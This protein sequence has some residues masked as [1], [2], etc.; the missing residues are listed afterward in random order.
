MSKPREGANPEPY[1][2]RGGPRKSKD[3]GSYYAADEM[4]FRAQVE[5]LDEDDKLDGLVVSWPLPYLFEQAPGLTNA[6][7]IGK[8]AQLGRLND[9]LKALGYD[10]NTDDDIPYSP[11]VLPWLDSWF[12][13]H[14]RPFQMTLNEKG[15]VDSTSLIKESNLPAWV[16]KHK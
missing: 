10:P 12:L 8:K 5:I 16:S 14:R 7:L 13:A 4:R 2:E 15:F 6:I 1:I 11:N 9:G 3:G